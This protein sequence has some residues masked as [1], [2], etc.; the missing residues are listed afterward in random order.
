LINYQKEIEGQYNLL[1][2]MSGKN[3]SQ[4]KDDDISEIYQFINNKRDKCSTK[5]CLFSFYK[6]NDFFARAIEWSIQEINTKFEQKN[7]NANYTNRIYYTDNETIEK[8]TKLCNSLFNDLTNNFDNVTIIKPI[9]QVVLRDDDRLKK[10]LGSCYEAT[11]NLTAEPFYVNVSPDNYFSLWSV[12]IDKDGITELVITQ[13]NYIWQLLDI[14]K[15]EAALKKQD[16]DSEKDEVMLAYDFTQSYG[17]P[18]TPLTL[19]RYNN[20]IIILDFYKER[21]RSRFDTYGGMYIYTFYAFDFEKPKRTFP[22]N[23]SHIGSYKLFYET[24]DITFIK[25][26]QTKR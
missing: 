12:D 15:C 8:N 3:N 25:N 7:T 23:F 10:A 2:E 11:A 21:I 20:E 18:K 6:N 14:K 5:E 22:D 1:Y 26:K 16:F 17:I 9:V 19:I 13:N 24:C 4:I